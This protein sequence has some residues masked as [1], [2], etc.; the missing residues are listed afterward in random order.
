MVTALAP[1]TARR[2]FAAYASNWEHI[3]D[4]LRRLDLRLRLALQKQGDKEPASPLDQFRGLVLSEN[5]VRNLLVE[6]HGG[7]EQNGN[8]AGA[9]YQK[10]DSALAETESEIDGRR[11]ATSEATVY[12]SVA[13]LTRLFALKPFE[14]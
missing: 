3:D 7:V 1:G 6:E 9:E 12:L 4:E 8:D 11:A 10:L 13:H 14:V 5:Q 2:E